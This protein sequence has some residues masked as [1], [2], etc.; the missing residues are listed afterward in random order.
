MLQEGDHSSEIVREVSFTVAS[1]VYFLKRKMGATRRMCLSPL[2]L[3]S[4]TFEQ[5][6]RVNKVLLEFPAL[7]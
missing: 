7:T 4:V 6:L 1:E 3:R 2:F 5:N